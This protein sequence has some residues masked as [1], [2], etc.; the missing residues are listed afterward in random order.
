MLSPATACP[1]LTDLDLSECKS[2]GYVLVQSTSVKTVKL[3]K[4]EALTKV[5]VAGV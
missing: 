1:K 3:H 5:G 2:L 4:N